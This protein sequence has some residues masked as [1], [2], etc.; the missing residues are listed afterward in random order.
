MTDLF[1]VSGIRAFPVKMLR[2]ESGPVAGII[3]EQSQW[4]WEDKEPVVDEK[5]LMRVFRSTDAGRCVDF[6]IR[7]T[8]LVDDLKFAGQI[9]TGYSGFNLRMAPIKEKEI[10]LS[11][12][13]TGPNSVAG[14]WADYSAK[15]GEGVSGVAIV[16]NKTNPLYPQN[17]RKY[18]EL[19][20]FQPLYPDSVLTPM[21]KG[22]MIVLKYRLWIHRDK[23]TTARL[24]DIFSSYNFVPAG[25]GV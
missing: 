10:I 21:P 9:Q 5:V 11:S 18:P 12:D 23:A 22:Q 8:A 19:N 1:A 13:F 16:Q 15:F 2:A 3:E 24:D 20:F 25:L 14:V 4:K 17:W 6:E 7:L